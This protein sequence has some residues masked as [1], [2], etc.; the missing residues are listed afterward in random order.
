[1]TSR[2]PIDFVLFDLGGVLIDPGGVG[3]MREL[4]GLPSDDDVWARWLSC[5]WVRAFEAGRC[6]P[7]EFAAGVVSDWELDLEPDAFLDE[8]AGWPGLPYPGALEL[9]SAVAA[10]VPIGYLSNT[11]ALQ[12][13]ANFEEIPVTRAFGYRFL[14]F[15]LGLVKP[16]RE[17]FDAVAAALPVPRERVL[18]LDDNL[19]NVEAALAAG[20][21]ASHVRGVDGATDALVG[22]GVL[23]R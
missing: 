6:S 20:F 4:S 8:F 13:N 11:N 21:A 22:A 12:W 17:I 7:E 1:M 9:V 3:Q 5:R 10:Q 18:F 2:D 19:V 14:S 23:P 15:Q 16:D